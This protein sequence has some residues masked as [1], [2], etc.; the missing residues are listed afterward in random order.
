M[1]ISYAITVCN[2]VDET[3]RL[4]TK[5]LETIREEDEIVIL[6]DEPKCPSELK[7]YLIQTSIDSRVKLHTSSFDNNFA[8]WKNLLNSLCTGDYI[9]QID[10]D[11]V[12]TEG[13][14]QQLPYIIEQQPD[15]V[16]VPRVNIVVDITYDHIKKWGWNKDENSRINWPDYQWRL[17][18]NVAYIKWMNKVHERLEGFKTYALLPAEEDYALIH[19]K[20]IERQENQNNFYDKL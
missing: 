8:D 13:L 12:P 9:F 20:T 17:Y 7:Q 6:L 11:E 19:V 1:K 4:L 2:E 14:I 18:K 15:V 16:L 3:P 5:L 10:A